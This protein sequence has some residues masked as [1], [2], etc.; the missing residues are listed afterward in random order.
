MTIIRATKE[1]KDTLNLL[2]ETIKELIEEKDTTKYKELNEKIDKCYKKLDQ[3]SKDKKLVETIDTVTFQEVI[4]KF[5]DYNKKNNI[6]FCRETDLPLI[7]AVIVYKKESFAYE[8]SE[9]ERSYKINNISSKAFFYKVAPGTEYLCGKCLAHKEQ[10]LID[11]YNDRW[12]IDYCY[13][14]NKE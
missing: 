1:H 9:E 13:F 5:S 10:H 4:E 7:E 11:L 2:L 14:L 6:K 3:L 12:E 8:L